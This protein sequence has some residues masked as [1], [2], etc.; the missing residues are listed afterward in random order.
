MRKL[1]LVIFSFAL[2]VTSYGQLAINSPYSSNGIGETEGLDNATFLGIG[3]VRISMCDSS[4]LNYYNPASYS[5]L[6][7]G[8][9][10]FSLGISSRLSNYTEANVESFSP[11][12]SVQHFAFG[13]SFAK[14]LGMAFGLQ[15]YSRRGYSFSTGGFVDQDSM[16]YTYEGKGSISNAFMGLSATILKFDS[17]RLSVGV[18]AGYLFGNVTNTRTAQEASSTMGGLGMKTYDLRS[19]HYDLGVMFTH[20]INDNHSFGLYATYDPLQTLKS[21]Y[22]EE[23]YFAS[24]VSNTNSIIDT[25]VYTT[26]DGGNL[27]NAPKLSYGLRYTY[28]LKDNNKIQRKLHPEIGLYASYSTTDWSKYENS[29]ATDSTQFMNTS[30]LSV[31]VQF[32][33]E[34]EFKI[35]TATTNIFARIRYRAGYYQYTLPYSANGEQVTDFGTTFGFGIPVSIQKSLSSI[36]FGFSIG[37]R[38]VSDQQQLSEKYYGINLGITIAPGASEKWFRKRKLN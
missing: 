15:P 17:T 21:S 25:N 5:A 22:K 34:S 26:R 28:R 35:N 29:Y 23:V 24:D 18:N 8:Q 14:Y 27:T 37:Q 6:A 7:K 9:P 36:N 16:T 11:I 30:K 20:Q 31:G 13:F 19:F 10:L 4:T 3:N 38:G 2:G 32:I 12:T 1:F 33:P